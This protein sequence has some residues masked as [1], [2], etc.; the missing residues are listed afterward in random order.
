MASAETRRSRR[1]HQTLDEEF[2]RAP[3]PPPTVAAGDSTAVPVRFRH[4]PVG[5]TR[6][7]WVWVGAGV[8]TA[9]AG[10][11]YRAVRRR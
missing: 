5:R 4:R 3:E 8:L 9:V 2:R 7:V 11:V 10:A 1:F 6:R